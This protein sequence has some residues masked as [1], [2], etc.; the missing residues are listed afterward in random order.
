M[1]NAELAIL[2][3]IVEK[4]RHGYELEVVIEERGMREWTE[5][6][7][8]SIYYLLKK[9]EKE[10]LVAGR[11]EQLPGRGPARKVYQAT[12][13]GRAAWQEA[14]VDALAAPG[15]S[16]SAFLLGL[17]NMAALPFDQVLAACRQYREHLVARRAHVQAR[18]EAGDQPLPFHV[19]A[20]FEYSLALIDAEIDWLSQFIRQLTVSG[21]SQGEDHVAATTA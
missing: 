4:P 15:R 2:S 8:S 3:L 18:S 20:M 13:A 17:S 21:G 19:A 12:P 7:F 16:T 11:L 10:G 5:V 1:T 14:A 6:G 9:L